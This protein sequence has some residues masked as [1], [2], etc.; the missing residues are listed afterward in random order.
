MAYSFLV[1]GPKNVNTEWVFINF[2]EK[3][4]SE[5]PDCIHILVDATMWM[6]SYVNL[7]NFDTV[8]DQIAFM[9]IE[10]SKFQL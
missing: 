10:F 1:K 9:N 6:S 4:D 3:T 2:L 7:K 8:A 5:I